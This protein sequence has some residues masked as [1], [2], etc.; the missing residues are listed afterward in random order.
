MGIRQLQSAKKHEDAIRAAFSCFDQN[1]DGIISMADFINIMTRKSTGCTPHSAEQAELVFSSLDTNGNGT[2]AYEE[3]VQAWTGSLGSQVEL[4]PPHMPPTR[5][6]LVPSPCRG[7]RSCHPRPS[8]RSRSS[9]L[10]AK[11]QLAQHGR[12]VCR[13]SSFHTRGCSLTILILKA[14]RSG[15]WVYA[16]FVSGSSKSASRLE[17]L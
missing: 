14:I 7:V 3:F 1:G 10:S 17:R 12:P 4:A 15:C 9:S 8:S 5:R 11:W 2:L 16:V 13:S 6:R